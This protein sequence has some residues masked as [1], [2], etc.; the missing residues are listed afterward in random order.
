[1]IGTMWEDVKMVEQQGVV[2]NWGV[3]KNGAGIGGNMMETMRDDVERVGKFQSPPPTLSRY[4]M[5][6]RRLE[7]CN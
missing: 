3:G 1:M 5:L 6:D 4:C 2:E 7:T